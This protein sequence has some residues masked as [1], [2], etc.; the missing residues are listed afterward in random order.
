MS[1]S[2]RSV[3]NRIAGLI[4]G[5]LVVGLVVLALNAGFRSWWSDEQDQLVDRETTEPRDRAAERKAREE[6]RGPARPHR[7]EASRSMRSLDRPDMADGMPAPEPEPMPGVMAPMAGELAALDGS[8]YT[9]GSRDNR[10]QYPDAEDNP[11]KLVKE[12][13]VSTFSVDVD[14]AS[15]SLMRRYLEDGTLPPREGIRVEELINYFN[16]D[17]PLPEDRSAPFKPTV[18]VAPAPWNGQRQILRIGIKGFD[19]EPDDLPA[20]NLVFLIDVS[21]SMND[22]RKLPLVK[23]SLRL[24]TGQMREGDTIGIVVYA[25]A[26]GTALEPTSDQSAVLAALDKLEA[27]GSTAGAEGIRQAYALAE[28]NFDAKKVNRVI[29]ASDGDF[30]VGIT[31][32]KRLEDFIAEKRKTGIF[33]T[34]LTFGTGNLNDVI[35]QKLAQAG[36]GNAAYIDRL[37]EARKV[38]VEEMRSTI[39][40][41]AKDVKIQIEFNPARVSAYRLIG[42]ETRLL[43]REDFDNDAVDAGDIGSGHTVTALY[44][45]YPPGTEP[46]KPLRYGDDAKKPEPSGKA[47][48]FAFL[49]MRY[50]LPDQDKSRL[51]ERAIVS[52]DAR[53]HIGNAPEDMR[54]AAAV[55]AFG[56]RLRGGKY[57]GVFGY[58]DIL[59]LA[60]SALGKDSYGYRTEFL[61]LVRKAKKAE[62][63]PELAGVLDSA[64]QSLVPT[65]PPN[66]PPCTDKRGEVVVEFIVEP[67]GSLSDIKT[68]S[69]TSECFER[70]A[71]MTVRRWKYRPQ[72]REGAIVRSD[73]VRVTIRFEAEE[74]ADAAA[75]DGG[76][77]SASP[78]PRVE[79]TDGPSGG[80]EPEGGR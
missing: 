58:D 22:P 55:A 63:F 27:G 79:V 21:G 3:W 76:D 20:A 48:E 78:K 2:S 54:F 8:R 17:Y 16:Y 61:E 51:I 80:K 42:Y 72:V 50:K 69:A 36:N 24:L 53:P 13:P 47:D 40:P 10:E 39:F 43:K 68:V 26:A 7:D 56:Q 59:E 18:H 31:D 64:P 6:G 73:P 65:T 5:I 23:E 25:G 45:I 60:G 46:I 35:A 37:S 11:V 67:D 77:S 66:F 70:A 9:P 4:V 34:V 28:R 14:T 44:E 1:D 52:A 38:L 33:L 57:L 75:G 41:I 19:I 49:R 29:L 71:L 62:P 30:N 32:P 12:H 74:P 15:Y